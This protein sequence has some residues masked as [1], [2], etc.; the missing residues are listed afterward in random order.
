MS[1]T[2]PLDLLHL[3]DHLL[4][5]DKPAGLL[6]HASRMAADVDE[7]LLD[8]LRH[9]VGGEVFLVHRLDRATSGLVLAARTR[10]A[11]GELGKQ[12]M[13]RTVEKTYLAVCRGWPAETGEIDYA[14]G[15]VRP[16]SPKKPAL[17]RYRRLATVEVPIALG[18]Y[19]QQR[20]ALLAVDP[21]TG[22]YRQIR[23][24]FHHVSHHLIG[25]TSHGR[26]EHNRLFQSQWQVSRLLL[27]ARRLVF[28]HPATGDRLAFV[29][30]L[31]PQF[32]RIVDAVGWHGIAI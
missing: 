1:A 25:D 31:D 4:V 29:A 11:A 8:Q 2:E 27:H 10:E 21:V 12:F 18:K 9:Q 26:S 32:Q 16:N 24:H 28:T 7:D 5:V 17:T 15:D 22:R 14:L 30:P 13:A 20:Y 19:P 6:A 23:K 3:D